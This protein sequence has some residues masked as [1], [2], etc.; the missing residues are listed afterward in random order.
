MPRAKVSE[1]SALQGK[2]AVRSA[3]GAL[4]ISDADD[5]YEREADRVA[6]EVMSASPSK[7]HWSLSNIR[8]S[9]PLQRK[10]SCGSIGDAIGECEECQQKKETGIVQRKADAGAGPAFAPLIVHEVLNS[11]GQPLDRATR[12]FFEVKFDH[13]FSR[14]R[15]HDDARAARSAKAINAIAYT[16]GSSIVLGAQRYSSGS[17]E[18]ELLAHELAHVVQQGGVASGA[19]RT[20]LPRD[21]FAEREARQAAR[22]ALGSGKVQIKA[23]M[24]T[25]SIGRV[26][27]SDPASEKTP[28]DVGQ[29]TGT[30]S[31]KSEA[32]AS[33]PPDNS[34]PQRLRF[35]IIGAE[36]PLA[37]FLAQAAAHSRDPDLRV[38]SLEDMVKQLEERAPTASKRCIEHIS[39]YNHGRPG[40][41]VVAG[42]DPEKG[43]ESSG[44]PKSYLDLDWLYKPANQEMLKRLRG[45]FCC[46]ASMDWL[47]CGVAGVEATGGTRSQEE[48]A[49]AGKIGPAEEGSLKE[50]FQEMG[51]DRYQ[52]E[53][54]ALKHRANLQ[55]ATFGSTT[56]GTWADA[57]C[58][59][60]RAATDFV[61]YDSGT[62]KYNV[63]F[64][65]EFLNFNPS[66]AQCSC[67]PATG[68]VQGTWDPGQG[69]DIGGE[70]WQN[71]LYKLNRTLTASP[72]AASGDVTHW[73]LELLSDVS[74]DLKIPQGLPAGAKVE[75]WINA[76]ST[77]P[78]YVARTLDY[79][80]LCYP[81]DCWKWIAVNR[82][83]VQQT[84]AYTKTTLNHELEHALDMFVAAFEYKLL[85]GPPPA[86]PDAACKPGYEPSETDGYGKYVLGFRQYYRDQLSSE[87]HLEIYEKTA[88]PNFQRFTP[89]EKLQWFGG[90]ITEVPPDVPPGT[91][92]PTEKLISSI[93][94]SPLPYE[95]ELRGQ[96]EAVLYRVVE[97]FIYGDNAGRGVDLGK[98]RTLISHFAPVWHVRPR[99]R[100]LLQ[101]GISAEEAKPKPSGSP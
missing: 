43:K 53:A 84:P 97:F 88:A 22:A 63:G 61:F 51:V 21:S 54:D 41:Q 1:T 45:V 101:Q 33:T 76:T 52:T 89:G 9:A 39:I 44:L 59:S 96:L 17:G 91:P 40:H 74:P 58:T 4:R 42:S 19:S 64:R 38:S 83:I 70:K 20:L 31:S 81:N 35:D 87:R 100:G 56:V 23:S 15:I 25:G 46:G 30:A 26:E 68:R 10:C 28:T 85:N 12:S 71:D 48:I 99:D 11:P 80:V 67:D 66:A 82:M 37:N 13:D 98:A 72:A 57:T 77:N 49:A 34:K 50:R 5:P 78:N 2:P 79:L 3:H 69:I 75:P 95:A 24:P 62:G 7:R 55:G 36:L 86:A 29:K 8:M 65:G 73:I 32:G 27:S 6:D 90:M 47:G 18:M 94:T 92:L 16:A 14:V 60:I 93:Y